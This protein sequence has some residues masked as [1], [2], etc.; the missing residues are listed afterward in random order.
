V[1]IEDMVLATA[2]DARVL[3]RIPK[4]FRNLIA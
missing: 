3:T 2:S 4:Q 1:R